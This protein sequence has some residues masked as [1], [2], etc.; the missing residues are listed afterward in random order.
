MASSWLVP[1]PAVRRHLHAC[2]GFDLRPAER[3]ADPRKNRAGSVEVSHKA[4]TGCRTWPWCMT[5]SENWFQKRVMVVDDRAHAKRP[6]LKGVIATC[7]VAVSR[8]TRDVAL[9]DVPVASKRPGRGYSRRWAS[10]RSC[11]HIVVDTETAVRCPGWCYT[12]K[13]RMSLSRRFWR[14]TRRR[15][16]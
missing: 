10:G 8:L 6:V 16:A 15:M 7:A 5:L 9:F 4:G 2:A 12:A 3:S 1:P 13:S 14:R 11:W